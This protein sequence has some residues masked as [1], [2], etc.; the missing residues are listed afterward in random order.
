MIS[1]G[2]LIEVL[3]L[4]SSALV[5]NPKKTTLQGGQSHSWSAEQEKRKR[6]EK[7]SGSATPSPPALL[8]QFSLFPYPRSCLVFC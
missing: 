3:F 5:A 8:V 2:Q 6:K 4:T 7:E 1:R